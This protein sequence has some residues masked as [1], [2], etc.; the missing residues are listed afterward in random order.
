MNR[1]LLLVVITLALAIPPCWAQSAAT[2]TA[3]SPT[4]SA[5]TPPAQA[6][7]PQPPPPIVSPDVHPDGTVTFRF[8]DP[9]A[10]EV[11]LN[12]EGT[13]KPQPMEKDDQG[14]WSITTQPLAPDYYGYTFD[15]DG[16]N[17]VDPSN[18]LMKTNLLF[19]SNMVHV[20]GAPPPD[21]ETTDVPHGVVHHYFYHSGVVGDDRDYFVYTPPGYNPKAKTTYPVLYLQHG[22]SDGA[23]GWTAVGRANFI[24]DNLIAQDKVEPMLIVMSLGYGAPEILHRGPG[25][26]H[27]PNLVQRNMDKFGEALITEV[28][29]QVEKDFRVKAD[30]EHRAL[31][32]LSMG[33]AESL[34]VGL[35]HL[36]EFAWIGSFS[37][38]GLGDNYGTEFPN[39]GSAVNSQVR[40]LWIACGTDDHLIGPNRKFREW[41]TSKGIQHTDIETPGMH[42]WMVW[43]RNLIAFAPL[44]FQK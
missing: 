28:I 41:L 22:Y 9:N 32:G 20:P 42:T 11:G 34:Y 5:Q 24:L 18:T 43:R 38:G 40:L 30:R 17:L 3:A 21:W 13:T 4:A 27:D 2:S 6:Q 37:A 44:L 26:F 29:P 23:D 7:R 25:S 19:L 15:A 33:G 35:N 12:L 10:Q 16:V 1:R 36:D 39:L 31:A 14:V 8:R